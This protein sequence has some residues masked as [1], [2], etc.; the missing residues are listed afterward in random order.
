[1]TQLFLG[2]GSNIEPARY[3]SLGLEELEA[4]LGELRV[5][6]VYEGAAIGFAGAP[7]WNLVVETQTLLSVGDLQA[8][9]RSI[10][11]AH[12]RP[13]NASRFSPRSLDIDILVYGDVCGVIEGVVLP[14]GEI[15]DNAFVLR[16]LAELAPGGMHPSDGRSYAELW[17]Q[18]DTASQPLRAVSLDAESLLN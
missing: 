5:S 2:L 18:Y 14:R 15:L 7:F 16:P 6:S 11:Y 13:E 1:M 10:E 8:A 17:Q 4:L 12:G 9:L 3:L